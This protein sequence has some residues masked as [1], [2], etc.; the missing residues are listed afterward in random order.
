MSNETWKDIPDYDGYQIS[1]LGRIRSFWT[2]G[3]TAKISD[4]PQRILKQSSDG[5]GYLQVGKLRT[6]QIKRVHQLVMLAFV[7]PCP[8]DMTVC[9]NNNDKTDNRLENLRYDTV[10]ANL[11]DSRNGEGFYP[12][13]IIDNTDT[14]IKIMRRIKDGATY[15]T[16]ADE[17]DITPTLV[18]KIATGQTYEHIDRPTVSEIKSNRNRQIRELYATGKY[19]MSELGHQFNLS[20]SGVSRIINKNRGQLWEDDLVS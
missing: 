14:I 5:N 20:E 17:F 8:D 12:K 3:R 18:A 16:I 13:S 11:R 1:N 19:R 4:Q 10:A 15:S 9:H 2:K 6:N 7:G